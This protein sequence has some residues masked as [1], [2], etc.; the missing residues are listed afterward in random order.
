MRTVHT[1][2]GPPVLSP[3][4][5]LV[6]CAAKMVAAEARRHDYLLESSETT[7][8]D[9]ERLIRL[10]DGAASD[11]ELAGSLLFLA[12]CLKRHHGR[13]VL[14]LLDEYDAPVTAAY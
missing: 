13:G 3:P 6:T 12:R 4:A 7:P 14:V 11:A 5:L 9:H 1:L 10:I 2:E 8:G